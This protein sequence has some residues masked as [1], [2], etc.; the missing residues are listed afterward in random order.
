M[1]NTPSR[2]F[3]MHVHIVMARNVNPCG[4]WRQ[5]HWNHRFCLLRIMTYQTYKEVVSEI[6]LSV[7]LLAGFTQRGLLIKNPTVYN[8]SIQQKMEL[9]FPTFSGKTPN[10][11]LCTLLV[12]AV[13][14]GI[15]FGILHTSVRVGEVLNISLHPPHCPSHCSRVG[16]GGGETDHFGVLPSSDGEVWV[17]FV[18]ENFELTAI[19]LTS[20]P[21]GI[22]FLF[23]TVVPHPY[24][25]FSNKYRRR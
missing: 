8:G 18:L 15:I 3:R 20:G 5:R 10:P 4:H 1:T 6:N 14:T 24:T 21:G 19:Q 23:N 13:D 25:L 2:P 11:V 17:I 22:S 9:V 7:A 16:H 12:E